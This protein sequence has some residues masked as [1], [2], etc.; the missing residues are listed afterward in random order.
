MPW[1]AD[2]GPKRQTETGSG[3]EGRKETNTTI[4]SN[5]WK[6]LQAIA[7]CN[8]VMLS[9]INPYLESYLILASFIFTFP[10]SL[11]FLF[12]HKALW[13]TC[14]NS[15]SYESYHT[16][17]LVNSTHGFPCLIKPNSTQ[18]S[19]VYF[20]LPHFLTKSNSNGS[21]GGQSL[22]CAEWSSAEAKRSFTKQ[23]CPWRHKELWTIHTCLGQKVKAWLELK[24]TMYFCTILSHITL[25][26]VRV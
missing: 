20:L 4:Q 24:F 17:Q 9:L 11:C 15:Q 21:V 1:S 13:S 3:L 7:M 10:Y 19:Y 2:T 16:H 18:Q 14:T 26:T 25:K 22:F 12:I 5:I 23:V 8:T 6:D